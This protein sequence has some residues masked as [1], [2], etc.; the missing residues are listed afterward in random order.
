MDMHRRKYR[1]KAVFVSGD[2]ADAVERSSDLAGPAPD[3]FL[4]TRESHQQVRA[5][6]DQMD[7]ETDRQILLLRFVDDLSY[8]EIAAAVGIPMG[9]VMSRLF[10][11]KN[12]LRGLLEPVREEAK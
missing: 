7:N 8:R 10:Y 3:Q 5:A 9:T 6:L 11:A 1:E 2:G 4:Q 12:K